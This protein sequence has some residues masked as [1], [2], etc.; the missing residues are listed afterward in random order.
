MQDQGGFYPIIFALKDRG[1]CAI[2]RVFQEN[3]TYYGGQSYVQFRIILQLSEVAL[4][5]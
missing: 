4:R 2:L 5:L 3:N 1:K